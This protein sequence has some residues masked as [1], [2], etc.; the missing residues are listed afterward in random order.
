MAEGL[1][2]NRLPGTGTQTWNLLTE[3]M[4]GERLPWAEGSQ[5]SAAVCFRI[6]FWLGPASWQSPG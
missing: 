5:P 3:G 2:V 1:A 4:R 6:H